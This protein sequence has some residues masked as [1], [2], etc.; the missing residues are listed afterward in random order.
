MKFG[1]WTR[2]T[3]LPGFQTGSVGKKL[4]LVFCISCLPCSLW[5]C[6]KVFWRKRSWPWKSTLRSRPPNC[7]S[8]C[9]SCYSTS[10]AEKTSRLHRKAPK[11]N[12]CK[13][14]MTSGQPNH[15]QLCVSL[16]A[17]P[18][19]TSSFKSAQLSPSPPSS[20]P[21]P[22]FYSVDTRKTHLKLSIFVRKLYQSVVNKQKCPTTF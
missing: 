12:G 13:L 21:V 2:Q 6:Q 4:L 3:G 7:C 14:E 22:S 18:G 19:M 9:S 20:A 16:F 8:H 5:S 15:R 11:P 10:F 1:R 17:Q